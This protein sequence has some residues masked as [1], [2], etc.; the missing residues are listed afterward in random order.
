MNLK[1]Y[2]MRKR[3]VL[4]T[5]FVIFSW[6]IFGQTHNYWTTDVSI[7]PNNMSVTAKVFIDD[8]EQ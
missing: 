2:S 1:K 5:L 3:I 8:I 7:Y 6:Q 4:L